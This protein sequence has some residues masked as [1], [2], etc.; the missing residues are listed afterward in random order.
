MLSRWKAH[1]RGFLPF[2][3]RKGAD[4]NFRRSVHKRGRVDSSLQV[5]TGS[6]KIPEKPLH[7]PLVPPYVYPVL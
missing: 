2:V 5:S 3:L 4:S 6:L 7:S 1:L